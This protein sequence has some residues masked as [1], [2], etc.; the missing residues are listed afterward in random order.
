[1][2][3]RL[4][5]VDDS[6]SRLS[7]MRKRMTRSFS[8]HKHAKEDFSPTHSKVCQNV[9][10]ATTIIQ[11]IV[12]IGIFIALKLFGNTICKLLTDDK[13]NCMLKGKPKLGFR[14]LQPQNDHV[15]GI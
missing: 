5:W 9:L 12:I 14:I 7:L 13:T 10:L 2:N 1:M 3:G 4:T 6:F 8:R 11:F 15:H